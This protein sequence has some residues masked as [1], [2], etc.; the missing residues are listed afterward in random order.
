MTR[1]KLLMVAVLL[2]AGG[3]SLTAQ[4]NALAGPSPSEGSTGSRITRPVTGKN[5]GDAA[6]EVLTSAG[7]GP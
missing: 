2:L 4:S 6:S 3:P 1:I 5:R 7:A